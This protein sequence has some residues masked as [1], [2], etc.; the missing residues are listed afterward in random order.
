E[1][2]LA[3]LRQLRKRGW[4][5][6]LVP[7]DSRGL[8]GPDAVD[9]ACTDR[10]ALVSVMLAN[11][12]VGTIQDVATIAARARARGILVHTDA[13]QAVGRIPVDVSVLGVDLLSLSGHKFYGPKGV[14]ALWIRRGTRLLATATGGRQERNRRAGTENVPSIVGLGVA[15]AIAAESLDAD[16]RRIGALRD[17][18]EAGILA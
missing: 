17:R 9:A 1:A 12:E 5:V 3:T 2:I 18:L 13:V 7:A 4:E 16:A 15:A 6:T 8:V 14:G 10:T 11:N